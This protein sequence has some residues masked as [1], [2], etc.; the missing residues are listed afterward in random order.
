MLCNAGF[1]VAATAVLRRRGWNNFQWA[2]S[3]SNSN[4]L[5]VCPGQVGGG[6]CRATELP[7]RGLYLFPLLCLQTGLTC[8]HRLSLEGLVLD[9]SLPDRH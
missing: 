4:P 9:L 8:C 1:L 6:Q 3:S 7:R 2:H 5:L